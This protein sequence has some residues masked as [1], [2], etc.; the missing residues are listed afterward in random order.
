MGVCRNV[1]SCI[2]LPN[3]LIFISAC[4]NSLYLNDGAKYGASILRKCALKFR[5]ATSDAFLWCVPG[6]T[7]SSCILYSSFIIFLWYSDTSLSSMRFLGIIP[8]RFSLNIIVLYARV[9][10]LFLQFLM[11]LTSIALMSI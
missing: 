1:G 7:S 4:G 9:S 11:G 3:G 8:A 10:S 5:M 2:G 6:G